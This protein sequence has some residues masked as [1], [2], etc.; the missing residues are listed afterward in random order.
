M[1]RWVDRWKGGG[2]VDRWVDRWK[3]GKVED[4]WIG[5]EV[6]RLICE[7]IGGEVERGGWVERVNRDDDRGKERVVWF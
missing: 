1:D 3:G 4:G 7:W 6:V 5:G 2:W